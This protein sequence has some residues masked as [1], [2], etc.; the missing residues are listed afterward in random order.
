MYRS[1]VITNLGQVDILC[2]GRG[3]RHLSLP[4]KGPSLIKLPALQNTGT[5]PRY[6]AE[7]ENQLAAYF[8]G[9]RIEFDI[10]LDL[11]GY[12]AFHRS[13]WMATRAIP[14]GETR[15]YG[16]VAWQVGSPRSARA[17]GQALAR[18]PV[19]VIIPCHR[20][21]RSDGTPG[22]FAGSAYSI[23]TKIAMLSLE[24]YTFS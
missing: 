3:L 1:S 6:L 16:W 5:P 7:L 13:V 14:Y 12:S 24:G 19:T 15:S 18:N 20:V 22:G 9:T 2:S 4:H 23:E 17:V 8:S 10:P 11:D 21:I